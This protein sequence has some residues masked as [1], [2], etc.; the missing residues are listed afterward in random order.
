M[1][2]L[3]T[4]FEVSN[5][6]PYKDTNSACRITPE[7]KY[8]LKNDNVWRD[9]IIKVVQITIY[10]L[11]TSNFSSHSYSILYTYFDFSSSRFA[12]FQFL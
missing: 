7:A 2:N 8:T 12:Q 9:N 5:F 6:T 3:C 4:K 1:I 11:S 10:Y